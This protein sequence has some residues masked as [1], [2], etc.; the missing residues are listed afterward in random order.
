MKIPKKPNY[1]K[2]PCPTD[3]ERRDRD[4]FVNL[5]IAVSALV[6]ALLNLFTSL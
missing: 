4:D 6:I 1:S 3:K 5:T 2:R